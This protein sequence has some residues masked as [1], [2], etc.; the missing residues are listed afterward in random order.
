MYRIHGRSTNGD[1]IVRGGGG[2]SASDAGEIVIVDD[3]GRVKDSDIQ[4]AS[5]STAGSPYGADNRV[6]KSDGTGRATQASGVTLSDT[7]V[8][9]GL[10]GVTITGTGA[11]RVERDYA[12][13]SGAGFSMV[14]T[15]D[16]HVAFE[17]RDAVGSNIL[18]QIVYR[19]T[20]G[21][22]AEHLYEIAD[23]DDTASGEPICREDYQTVTNQ[24]ITNRTLKRISVNGTRVFDVNV[25]NLTFSVPLNMNSNAIS[26]VT[27]LNSIAVSEIVTGASNLSVGSRLVISGLGGSVTES[28]VTVTGDQLS[29]VGRLDMNS[30]VYNGGIRL[31]R[32]LTDSGSHTTAYR[33]GVDTGSDPIHV[34]N[35]VRGTSTAVVTRPLNEWRNGG[36]PVMS[37]STGGLSLQNGALTD[38]DTLNGIDPS[39]I[40]SN[41]SNIT[42]ILTNLSTPLQNAGRILVSD[43]DGSLSEDTKEASD[44]TEAPTTFGTDNR[45]IRSHGTG[46]QLQS[47]GITIDDSNNITGVASITTGSLQVDGLV[48]D[49]GL[50]NDAGGIELR[51]QSSGQEI[52]L[53]TYGSI[54]MLI[55]S[56]NNS[57]ERVLFG[58]HSEDAS[59]ATQLME[60]QENQIEAFIP[61][62]FAGYAAASLPTGAAG[63]MIYDTTNSRF[64]VHNGTAWRVI[65]TSAI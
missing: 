20:A 31:T 50:I 25:G 11:Y 1:D 21:G 57:T 46:R 38:V 35:Y 40:T 8:M 59:L 54:D 6:I 58:A 27:S 28:N 24:N 55:D 42:T 60:I 29:T 30:T 48:I 12:T 64:L 23:A 19:P 39:Q 61:V 9:T 62:K 3:E 18:P 7:N 36:V 37:L 10:A 34:N 5:L 32:S 56:N 17:I 52:T 33:C 26:G 13:Q 4:I 43:G 22:R 51:V 65:T 53:S 16:S 15:A 49:N 14:D 44:L 47:S 45:L 2:I 41:Q 63:Q